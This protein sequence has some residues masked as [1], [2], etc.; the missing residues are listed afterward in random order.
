M[1]TYVTTRIN[2]FSNEKCSPLKKLPLKGFSS[3]KLVPVM[4]HRKEKR[5]L[6]MFLAKT[7]L[8]VQPLE[9]HGKTTPQKSL[10]TFC[11]GYKN[12]SKDCFSKKKKKVTDKKIKRSFFRSIE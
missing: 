1:K 4:N 8:K 7:S 3:R 6:A 2:N 12:V 10:A 5:L 11:D 9:A